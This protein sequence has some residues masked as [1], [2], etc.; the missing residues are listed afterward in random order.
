MQEHRHSAPQQGN[1]ELAAQQAVLHAAQV[2]HYTAVHAMPAQKAAHQHA[3]MELGMQERR[4]SAPRQEHTGHA[5]QQG[6]A[7]AARGITYIVEFAS[8]TDAEDLHR[9]QLR[10]LQSVLARSHQALQ[11]HGDIWT[12]LRRLLHARGSATQDIGKMGILV[13]YR[14]KRQQ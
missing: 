8:Q 13:F 2:I 3:L 12:R 11:S 6:V 4:R 10:E 1:T 9:Q 14:Q 5:A 7:H